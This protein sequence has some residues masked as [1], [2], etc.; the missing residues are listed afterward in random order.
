MRF[1]PRIRV[2]F[3][4]SY[5]VI[6]IFTISSYARRVSFIDS[7]NRAILSVVSLFDLGNIVKTE[8]PFHGRLNQVYIVET[9]KG[10]FVIK[11]YITRNTPQSIEHEAILLDSW[12][13]RG[14]SEFVPLPTML[15]AKDGNHCVDIDG[16]L[17]VV[18]EFL[19]GEIVATA[20]DLRGGRLEE[21]AR[22]MARFHY[23]VNDLT[24]D[25]GGVDVDVSSSNLKMIDWRNMDAELNLLDQLFSRLRSVDYETKDVEF[26]TLREYLLDNY[27]AI[28]F[29]WVRL[30]QSVDKLFDLPCSYVHGDYGFINTRFT[31]N[32]NTVAALFDWDFFRYDTRVLDLANLMTNRFEIKDTGEPYEFDME[33]YEEF[34]RGYVEVVVLEDGELD[35]LSEAWRYEYIQDIL[36]ILIRVA[37]NRYVPGDY[38]LLRQKVDIIQDLD[39]QDWQALKERILLAVPVVSNVRNQN[40]REMDKV[41]QIGIDFRR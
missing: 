29:H 41:R 34:L 15:K 35:V 17:Y 21:T 32:D 37:D 7:N 27:L 40:Q 3:A 16:E 33:A 28:R 19:D 20:E 9:I 30:G 25:F 10:K 31:P 6:S 8:K 39:N 22:V 23:L 5:V 13:E 18:Y 1:K 14:F 11:K 26:K 36:N 4:L 24:E 12:K 38:N 2:F